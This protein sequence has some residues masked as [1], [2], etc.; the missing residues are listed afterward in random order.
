MNISGTIRA[1]VLK[2]LHLDSK[3]DP[4]ASEPL[5]KWFGS[6]VSVILKIKKGLLVGFLSLKR[7]I[8]EFG[9]L[10]LKKEAVQGFGS[11]WKPNQ[12]KTAKEKN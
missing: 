9:F 11:V 5:K 7:F 3:S 6:R 12:N 2:F 8:F 10:F 4:D 1:T